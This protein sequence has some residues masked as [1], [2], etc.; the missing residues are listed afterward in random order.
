MIT[1]ANAKIN[2]GLHIV[3]RLPSGYHELQTVFYPI[4]T[5]SGTAANPEAFCDIIE[6]VESNADSFLQTGR[7]IDCDPE[8]N[9][10]VKA[11]RLFRESYPNNAGCSLKK[12]QVTLD[13]HLPDGAGMG[14]GSADASFTL[15]LLNEMHG[16][17]FSTQQLI[18]MAARIGADCAF[19]ICNKPA[20]A[21]GIGD[22]LSAIELS[23]GGMYI[24]VAKPD[25][26]ISTAKAYSLITPDSKRNDLRRILTEL[27]VEKWQDYVV[28]DFEKALFPLCPELPYLKKEMYDAGAA[29]ASMTG[30]GS[31]IYGLF[32]RRI[33]A[34]ACAASL[35]S[36]YVKVLT[37]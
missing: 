11:I 23:L 21:Q 24:V 13:K 28:N 27:P 10:V 20:Y 5:E 30:S 12:L 2:I 17:P 33:D 25:F 35:T 19:F 32:R 31:A 26:G 3:N 34:E 22:R 37:L 18:Q 15:R 9:L 1:F 7:E 29:Y 14:G 8:K 36:H 16:N 6:A 4:G